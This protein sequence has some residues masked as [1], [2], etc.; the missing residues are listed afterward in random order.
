MKQDDLNI[1]ED[2]RYAQCT[3][4]MFAVLCFFV[5]NVAIVIG[6]S[7]IGYNKPAD[8]V[9][10]IMGLPNWFFWGGI[11]GSIVAIVLS[12]LMVK[13]FFKE[14]SLDGKEE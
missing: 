2:P 7:M 9:N 12:I 4:E 11:I 6:L 10:I 5:V 1:E 13:L 8:E 3:K 14:M